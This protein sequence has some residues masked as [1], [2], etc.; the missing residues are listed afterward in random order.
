MKSS[1]MREF[2]ENWA[3]DSYRLDADM[4]EFQTRRANGQLLLTKLHAKMTVACAPAE[5]SQTHEDGFLRYG[6]IV[7]LQSAFTHTV[8]AVN[9]DQRVVSEQ[10]GYQV[11]GTADTSP[12]A[13]SAF[14]VRRPSGGRDDGGAIVTYGAPVCLALHSYEGAT[15]L[16][17]Q[18]QR[19]ALPNLGKSAASKKAEVA[20]VLDESKATVWCGARRPPRAARPPPPPPALQ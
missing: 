17:L 8:L 20:A 1:T 15:Q 2:K 19:L 12:M 9:M 11:S 13:R 16:L 14:T 7:M 6:D 3:E 18:T 4:L 10:I 5:L